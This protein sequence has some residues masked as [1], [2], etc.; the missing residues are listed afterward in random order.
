MNPQ[1]LPAQ[2]RDDAPRWAQTVVAFL[3]EKERR[4]GSRRTVEGYARMLWPFLERVGSPDRVTPAHVLAWAHGIGLSGREPSSAT[5]GARIACLSSYFRFLIRMQLA[6]ANPCDAL[7]RPRTVQAPARGLSAEQVRSL[8]VVVPDTVVGR[9]DRA[10]L[11]FFVLTGR[12]RAE[13]LGLTAGDISVEGETAFYSYRG[14]GGKRGRRELPRPAYQA[15]LAT[16]SD[17]GQDLASMARTGSLWQA[18]G[19]T[20]GVTG[21]TV[22]SRFRRYLQAAGLPLSGPWGSET[23][24]RARTTPV[25]SADAV[26]PLP[27]TKRGDVQRCPGQPLLNGQRDVKRLSGEEAAVGP[28]PRTTRQPIASEC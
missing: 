9:R 1:L 6:T 24:I 5:V 13:V 27:C 18:G 3:A 4:S 23:P 7:E 12:R 21:G 2:F 8:L 26:P 20:R 17:A 16:L 19:D 15:L 28:Q 11:L 25:R 14:K 10:L 22:Y